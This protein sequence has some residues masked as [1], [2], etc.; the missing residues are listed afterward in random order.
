MS[1]DQ[2]PQLP[3]G[4]FSLLSTLSQSL[5]FHSSPE[6]FISSRAPREEGP[7]PSRIARARILNRNVAVVSSHQIC[8]DILKVGS[9]EHQ[10]SVTAAQRGQTVSPDTFASRP[11]YLQLMSDFFPSPNILL[12][13][14]PDHLSKRKSW[15]EQLSSFPADSSRTIRGIANDHFSAWRQGNRIDIYDSMKDLSWRLLLSV[16][17][18]LSPTDKAYSTV[19][20]LQE[21]LLRGQFSLMPVS[22]NTPFWRSP[23]SRGIEARQKLQT[24]LKDHIASQDSGCPLLRQEKLG[25]DEISANALMFTSS[26]AVKALASLLTASMLNLFLLPCEPSLA[27]RVRTEDAANRNILLN[28][29]LLETERLSP[30]VVGVMRR[31]QQDVVLVSPEGQPPT[32]IPTGWDIWLYFVSAGRDKTAFE[33]ADQFL[34][35]RFISQAETKSGYAFGSG[36]KSCLGQHIVKEI[37]HSVASAALDANI[38]LEGSVTAQGVR[39]WL[40][41]DTGVSAEAFAGDLK[42]LPCQRPRESIYLRVHRGQ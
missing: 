4:D 39:G 19:E 31:V 7:S 34:P 40:G 1:G 16:F 26:I 12:V 5:S 14:Q 6:S 27:A 15:D 29:I 2:T 17:L 38:D 10:N 13:D 25:K 37:V 3:L 8:E 42:Q 33:L 21:T 23:R 9:G 32:L 36:S 41:W 28:S 24:L 22:I 18:Q 30:P 20:S 11:A 35:E